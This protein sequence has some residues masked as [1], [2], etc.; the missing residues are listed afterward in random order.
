MY[1]CFV[2]FDIGK[3]LSASD[4]KVLMTDQMSTASYL[5]WNSPSAHHRVKLYL[6]QAL[7]VMAPFPL[8]L[9]NIQEK[10]IWM[11]QPE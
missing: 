8:L 10:N 1:I 4:F 9:E 6:F 2:F 3:I 11:T 5:F 7:H